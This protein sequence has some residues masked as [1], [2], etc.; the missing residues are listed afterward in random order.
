LLPKF[1]HDIED[2]TNASSS[3]RILRNAC[4]MASPNAILRL[5]AASSRVFFRPDPH[6]LIAATARQVSDWALLQ[7]ENTENLRQAFRG[8]IDTLSELCIAKAGL[9]MEDIRCLHAS[10][11]STINPVTDMI[12]KCAGAQWYATPDFWG[13]GVSDAQTI[14]FDPPKSLLQIVIYGELFSTTML[15]AI[16]PVASLPRFDLDTRLDFVKYCFPDPMCWS[17]YKGLTVSNIGPYA[18]GD[19]STIFKI[20]DDQIRLNHILNCRTWREAWEKVRLQLGSD[21]ET[22]WKQQMWEAAVQLT[23]L[24]GLELL[25]PMEV[26]VRRERLVGTYKSIQRLGVKDRPAPYKFGTREHVAYGYPSMA[27][28]VRVTVS[29]YWG[30]WD[31]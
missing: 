17:A 13:G 10:R 25:R 11:F 27:D 23:G 21:F 5:A 20:E 2:F 3:Y 28:E 12:D 6:F 4:G 24:K 8:G 9:T 29:G 1:L 22:E 14:G 15:A 31:E 30:P 16:S 7:P 19:H 26:K 18:S